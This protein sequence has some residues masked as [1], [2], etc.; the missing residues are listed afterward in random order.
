MADETKI[1]EVDFFR[2]F[3]DQL[4][5]KG[6]Q[7]SQCG[8]KLGD[9]LGSR[10]DIDLQTGFWKEPS[11]SANKPSRWLY[12]IEPDGS[13]W[14]AVNPADGALNLGAINASQE[15]KAGVVFRL[16][17]LVQQGMKDYF[18]DDSLEVH[19]L[20]VFHG[21][22]P[23]GSSAEPFNFD[24]DSGAMTFKGVALPYLLAGLLGVQPRDH[25]VEVK[26]NG[27]PRTLT[28]GEVSDTLAAGITISP[29][30]GATAPIPV[31]DLSDKAEFERLKKN[32]SDAWKA[33][34]PV[35]VSVAAAGSGIDDE[36]EEDDD[37]IVAPASLHIPEMTDLLGI[38]PA[39]YRQ[40]NA[41]LASGK[42]HIML[43]GPPGTGKTT[44]ARHIATVL[45]GGKWTLVTGSSDWSSQDIIG[46]YQPIGSG[47]VAF[48]PGV[49][50]RRFDRPL[51]IDELNRCDI[52]KVI[53][54]LF[55]V[56]SG[57]QTTLP[58]RLDIED[59]DSLQYVILPESKPSAASHE[60]A[61]GPHWRL[62]AT[63]NSIDK[64]SLYQMSYALARRFGWV[65]V[66]APRDTAGFIEAFLRKE[67]PAW[68]GPAAGAPCPLGEFWAAIN[69]VRV[70][71]PAPIIDAMKAVQ[72][73]EED[74]K[75]F[76]VPDDSMK[77]ALLDA[78]DMVLLPML[79]GIVVQDAEFLA[80]KAVEVFGLDAGQSTRVKARMAS[81]AV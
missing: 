36:E 48:I 78:V 58:Y 11:Y 6:L 79:D 5:D 31:Y 68:A 53:G 55:T 33:V 62:V 71:G 65:Y 28:Y 15:D 45:T 44:L 70:I 4:K 3:K 37:E 41:A 52:D 18:R 50:L 49:L 63:I 72:S 16:V 81:V 43:Y 51:I 27:A 13:G 77:E 66:D 39:V 30:G 8:F 54:P 2:W 25:A 59:K 61:P 14:K 57:Q 40:I 60:F 35:A 75:F 21:A 19:A 12:Q 22:T 38:D 42:Q 34:G 76:A 9:S 17:P 7:F 10:H 64:A 1:Y 23:Q 32:I 20:F 24:P 26:L 73:M 46:G 80:G 69:S 56:L 47:S 67:E 29:E 74:A